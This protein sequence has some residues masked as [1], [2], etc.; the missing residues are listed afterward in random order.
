[1]SGRLP[2]RA[3]VLVAVLVAVGL[4]FE[5]LATL[6]LA[7]VVAVVIGLPIAAGA[8][9]FERRRVPRPLGAILCLLAG[10]GVVV[11]VL[12]LII[13]QFVEQARSF[14]NQLPGFIARRALLSPQ[15]RHCL[16]DD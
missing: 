4:L 13:P 16:Q 5:Q 1:M 15:A 12:G 11:G 2:Y 14:A 8:S 7:V 6:L 3:V 10:V 9:W